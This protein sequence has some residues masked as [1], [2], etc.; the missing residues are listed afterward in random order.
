ME[1]DSH[2]TSLYK[3]VEKRLQSIFLS[4]LSSK[5]KSLFMYI[6]SLSNPFLIF[7]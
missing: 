4:I 3:R 5:Y 1:E 2:S 6:I 7:E